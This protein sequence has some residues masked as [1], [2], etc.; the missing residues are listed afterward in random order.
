VPHDARPGPPNLQ[1]DHLRSALEF[2]VRTA[3][4]W[5][6]RKPPVPVP[7]E[8]KSFSKQQRLAASALGRVRRIVDGDPEFRARVAAAAVPELV[9]E[10]GLAWLRQDPGWEEDVRVLIERREQEAAERDTVRLLVQEQRRRV[11]AEDAA[12]RTRADLV[13]LTERIGDR[14]SE[15]ETLRREKSAGASDL[16]A[17]RQSVADL[18]LEARHSRDRAEAARRALERVEAERDDASR[19]AA[20][21]EAQRDELLAAR[22][23]LPGGSRGAAQIARLREL[24]EVA[25]SLG[26]QLTAL[27]ATGPRRRQAI[28]VPRP[29]AKDARLTAEFLLKVP[30]IVVLVD[31]Y[32][33]AKLGWPGLSLEQQRINMLDAVDALARRFGTEFV[34]VIDGADVVGAH[35]DRR[36]L[37]RV[38]YSPAGI[39]ADDVIREEVAGLDVGRAAA[40]VTNDREVRR[41]VMAAGANIIASDALIDVALG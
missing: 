25:R 13:A 18:K 3:A 19:R 15:L 11:A 4:A 37:T 24:S 27:I 12:I 17:L 26:E 28:E 22:A 33:V 8:I 31:G 23:E 29:A 21:A 14:E 34:V 41:D 10:I 6:K 16:E 40:V 7:P 9:D 39:K 5:Q 38:R 36:R 1:H 30:G 20:T 32:N 2:A 35:T